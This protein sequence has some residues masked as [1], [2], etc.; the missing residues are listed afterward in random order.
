MCLRNHTILAAANLKRACDFLFHHSLLDP[1]HK[2]DVVPENGEQISRIRYERMAQGWEGGVECAVCLCKI[3]EGEEIGEL[4]CDHLFHRVC[5]DR[6]LGYR[7][8]TCPLCRDYLSPR[9]LVSELG[10]EEVL[11]FKFSSFGSTN[12]NRTMWWLR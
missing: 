7:Q 11:V 3:E 6:W 8:A 1:D 4:R 10:E 9:R 2:G 12:R 5:L